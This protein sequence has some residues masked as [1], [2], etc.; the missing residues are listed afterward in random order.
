MTEG[1]IEQLHR[2]RKQALALCVDCL[3]LPLALYSA[4]ALRLGTLTPDVDGFWPAFVVS[5]LVCI[6]VFVKLGLYRQV[7]RYMGNHAM[8]S[9]LIGATIAAVAVAVTAYLVPLR[10]FPRSV[11]I[12]FWMLVL[13]YVSGTRFAVRALFQWARHRNHVREAVII[14]GAGAAGVGLSRIF[15]QQG[16]YVTVA[17]IDD[18]PAM[19]RRTIDGLAV[20][21][22]TLLERL[23]QD[24]EARQVFLAIPSATADERRDIIEFLERYPVRVRLLPPL[25]ELIT[26]R[27]SL[28]HVRDVAVED[29]L[30]RDEVDPLPRLLARSVQDRVVI[31]TGA[32]GSI[33]SELVRQIA[34]QSP[35]LLVLL[36]QN[37]FGL[38]RV[39]NELAQAHPQVNVLSVLGSVTDYPLMQRTLQRYQVETLYHAAAYKHVALVENNV[40]QGLINNTFGTLRTA[41]AAMACGV[42]SFI[43]ISTDKAVRTSSVMG[44]SKRLAEMCLQA[45]QPTQHSTRFAIVRF[46]NVLGSSGSVVPLFE[47]QI[48]RGGPV[49][50]THPEVTRYF[51]TIPEAAQLVLQA[52]S[53]AE[54]GDVFVLDMGRPIRILDLARRM[55]RL[56]GHAV[57][58]GEHPEG[59]IDIVFTG[60]K[61]GEKLHEELLL[62]TAVSGTEHRK[63]LRAEETFLPWSELQPAL[64]TLEKA[65][66]AYDYAAIKTF[67]EGLVEGASL[68]DQLGDLAVPAPLAPVVQLPAAASPASRP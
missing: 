18:D 61:P 60:L 17:F 41:Q 49:T 33:G 24:T 67:I 14:F 63:I 1:W 53:M 16:E 3:M 25:A 27:K 11:P 22:R 5:A 52:G 45:L 47:E 15:S 4:L 42:D 8:M 20:Y 40:I 68:E 37:E 44:A 38:F 19:Q 57:R 32:G 13:L 50:V 43:L 30:Y 28:T 2:H 12:I 23:L 65:C 29:L 10:G 35:R 48:E 36:D 62:G 39:E 46:G 34:R 7:I 9:V 64:A 31:V 56:K 54:G 55:I 58:D 26:G 66:S 59:D 21:A 6:P 51:M